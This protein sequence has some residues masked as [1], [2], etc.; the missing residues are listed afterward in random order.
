MFHNPSW[1]AARFA[2]PK[3]TVTMKLRTWHCPV[4]GAALLLIGVL[5]L[6]PSATADSPPVDLT[7]AWAADDGGV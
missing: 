5:I 1:R 4:S 3:E 6:P 7:G 2:R